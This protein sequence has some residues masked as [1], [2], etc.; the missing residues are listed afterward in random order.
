MGKVKPINEGNSQNVWAGLDYGLAIVVILQLVKF[1]QILMQK[2]DFDLCERFLMEEK[3]AQNFQITR[4]K[5][6]KL[7]EFYYNFH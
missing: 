6:F 1:L 7:P 5:R 3:I 4:E 2:Y